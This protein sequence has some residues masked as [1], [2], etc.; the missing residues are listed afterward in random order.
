MPLT[1]L[2]SGK[3][4]AIR[5][6]GGK[7]ESKRFLENLGFTVGEEVRIVSSNNGSIFV[8]VKDSRVA[9]SRG[10]ANKIVVEEMGICR[11]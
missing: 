8:Q 5:R 6:I 2:S 3:T 1:M 4:A 10:I 9:V 11:H 7:D